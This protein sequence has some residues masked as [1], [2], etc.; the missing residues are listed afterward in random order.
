MFGKKNP[1][2]N[3]PVNDNKSAHEAGCRSIHVILK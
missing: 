2:H 3:N 1:K